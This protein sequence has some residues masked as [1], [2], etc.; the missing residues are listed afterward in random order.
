MLQANIELYLARFERAVVKYNEIKQ[1]SLVA[2]EKTKINH[3]LKG[4]NDKP[5]IACGPVFYS[6]LNKK[7]LEFSFGFNTKIN[8]FNVYIGPGNR[9]LDKNSLSS[10]Y[11]VIKQIMNHVRVPTIV[12]PDYLKISRDS[13]EST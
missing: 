13:P 4:R 9:S 6:E 8:K 3:E 2:I 5:V 12:V 11:E 1:K 7:H 10:D